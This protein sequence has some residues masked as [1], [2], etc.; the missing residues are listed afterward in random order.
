[1]EMMIVEPSRQ[2]EL[3]RRCRSLDDQQRA[4]VVGRALRIGRRHVESIFPPLTILYSITFELKSFECY[5]SCVLV[6][7]RIM[8]VECVIMHHASSSCESVL[9][10][11]THE[12]GESQHETSPDDF[13]TCYNLCY[14]G[15]IQ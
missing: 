6:M 11:R 9:I 2:L 3:Y 1:M 4:I 14:N 13:L 7:N 5:V 12:S 10:T 15:G 8:Y